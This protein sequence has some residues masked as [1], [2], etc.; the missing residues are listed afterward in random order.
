VP[1]AGQLIFFG[2]KVSEAAYGEA[3]KRWTALGRHPGG[4]RSRA[5]L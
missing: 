4:I 5:A 3:L 2:D 1:R